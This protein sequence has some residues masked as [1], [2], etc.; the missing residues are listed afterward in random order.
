MENNIACAALWMRRGKDLRTW[1]CMGVIS[2][3]QRQ[4]GCTPH[5]RQ[6]RPTTDQAFFSLHYD[7]YRSIW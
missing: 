1:P 6:A 5:L 4:S 2:H 3:F 7:A